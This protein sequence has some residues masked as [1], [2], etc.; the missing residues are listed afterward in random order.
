MFVI[1]ASAR[2]HVI[3]S[4][5]PKESIQKVHLGT[6]PRIG[7]IALLCGLWFSILAIGPVHLNPL[8]MASTI[9]ASIIFAVG[10]AEDITGSL[11]VSWRLALTFIP[12]AMLAYQSHIFISHLGWGPVDALLSIGLVSIA[13]T[14]FALTGVT[15]AIN[16]IDGLNGLAT[17]TCL[18]ILGAYIGLG[19]LYDDH[20][21]LQIC[22][23]LLAPTL[24]FLVFN[25]PWGKCFLGDGGAYF[26]GF[27]IAWIGVLLVERHPA[28]SPFAPLLICGYPIIEALYSMLRRSL[29]G[30]SSGSPDSK[31]LHQLVKF[32]V[33]RPWLKDD[34]AQSIAPNSAAGLFMSMLSLPFVGLAVWLNTHPAILMGLFLLQASLYYL[35]HTKLTARVTFVKQR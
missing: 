21:I 20:L 27:F 23:L 9:A 34:R 35:L 2:H 19:Y 7:G 5:G 11:R 13:F 12:C 3:W 25:W 4:S 16:L 8:I 14:A 18:W 15:H 29:E 30:V 22:L 31:H 17:Y 24:G 28:I 32:G 6:V 33:I 10:F 1:I 26:L